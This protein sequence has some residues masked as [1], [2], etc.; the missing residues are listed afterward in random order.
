MKNVSFIFLLIA[1]L[2]I[3]GCGLLAS[4]EAVDPADS[5][6]IMVEVPSGAGVSKISA[7]L[8]DH[9]LIQSVRGFKEKVKA[10]DAET[11]LQ[12]GL[13]EL[14][15]TMDAESIIRKMVDGDVYIEKIRVVIPEGFELK[16]IVERLSE[17]GLIKADAFYAAMGNAS[18][19][20]RIMSELPTGVGRMEGF[21]FPAT[22]EFEKGAT[23]T[24]IVS[25][26]IRAFDLQFKP[27]WYDRAKELNMSVLEVVTLASIVE[28]EAKLDSERGLIAGV[29]E[30]RLR[31]NK[32]LESCATVQYALGERKT[33]LYNV[34][35]EVDS[36]YNT[37]RYRGLPPGPIA[38]P[39]T[40]SIEAVLYPEP[41]EYLFFRTTAKG[42]GSHDFSKTYQEHLRSGDGGITP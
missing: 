32:Q 17:A 8:K 25:Q 7:L 13:Y 39:G 9:D 38:S 20:F 24:E 6:P 34:D 18:Y 23:E 36:P 30:N 26:M 28:R 15:K 33:R 27:E 42:D 19:D 41:S 11:T 1:S 40:K 14:N 29:F 22:Y 2:F 21:L 31:M 3:S 10:M 16:Q 35:L 37:Y 4:V 5:S 12:A